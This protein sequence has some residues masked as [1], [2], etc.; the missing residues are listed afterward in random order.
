MTQKKTGHF[1]TYIAMIGDILIDFQFIEASLRIFLSN[2]YQYIAKRLSGKIPFRYDY[3]DVEKNALGTLINKFQKLNDNKSLISELKDLSKYRN[4]YAHRG[5]LLTYE[6][7]HDVLYL[8]SELKTLREI[9]KRTEQ[10]IS[11]LHK[12]WGKVQELLKS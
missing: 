11:V 2:S 12:E 10:C 3:R 8:E 1:D 7:M 5:F 6:Q 4:E 9:K